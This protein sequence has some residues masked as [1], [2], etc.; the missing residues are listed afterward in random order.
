MPARSRLGTCTGEGAPC[1]SA[2]PA[3]VRCPL[4][5]A[6]VQRQ[7]RGG[8]AR[9]PAV[10]DSRQPQVEA[11]AGP[12]ERNATL[13]GAPSATCVTWMSVAS[14]ATLAPSS[15]TV[16]HSTRPS[17]SS[18]LLS[19][20]V[21]CSTCSPRCPVSSHCSAREGHALFPRWGR[22]TTCHQ[23]TAGPTGRAFT[24]PETGRW[25]ASTPL[26]RRPLMRNPSPNRRV[27]PV[28]TVCVRHMR[29]RLVS[30][31]AG[32]APERGRVCVSGARRSSR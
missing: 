32:T 15:P 6:D 21:I 28:S 10:T 23:S 29:L 16:H 31:D 8:T 25:M 24:M 30:S 18:M 7:W 26:S 22:Y 27:S 14:F 4:R 20:L 5:G 17:V 1:G 11:V 2:A 3:Q 9:I 13:V 12:L 19:R